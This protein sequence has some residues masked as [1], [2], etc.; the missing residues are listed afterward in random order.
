MARIAITVGGAIAGAVVGY[1]F[2]PAGVYVWESTIGGAMAGAS[3]GS[4]VGAAVTAPHLQGPR[5][6]DLTV[7]SST[8]GTGIPFG[9]GTFRLGGNIIWSPGL[10]EHK[11]EESAK[12]GPTTTTYTYTASF[13][14]AFGEGPATIKRVW[15][16]S[17]VIYDPAA[18][19]GKYPV[20]S[21]YEGNETQTA[22]SII[23]AD[24]GAADTP[25]FRGLC[26][27]VW[28]DF[29]LADFGNRIPTIRAEVE[30]RLP[31]GSRITNI[32]DIV[33]DLCRRAGLDASRIDVS[34]LT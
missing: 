29:P 14:A 28:E 30:F 31:D 13:A 11:K 8:N 7:S 22:D 33:K 26:Y 9:Y 15:A 10:I 16:D 1:F 17:K 5:L 19:A 23:Q 12:G 32:G 4:S 27:A 24:I 25:A 2:P 3:V 34:L 21:I 18:Y 6:S 20:P